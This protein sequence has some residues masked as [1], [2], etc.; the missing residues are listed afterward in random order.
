MRNRQKPRAYSNCPLCQKPD[1]HLLH[2]LTRPH[3]DSVI[4]RHTL[5]D[6]LQSW[7]VREHIHPDITAFFL[8]GLNSW[9]QDMKF[10]YAV[11]IQYW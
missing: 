9:F 1:E 5:V 8:N 4:L 11:W 6:E 2:I 7:L 10:Q 3:P